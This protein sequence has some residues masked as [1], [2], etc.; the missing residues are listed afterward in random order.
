[1]LRFKD[2]V[3][4]VTGSA[5]GIGKATAQEFAKEGA[6][7][8]MCDRDAKCG[9][10]TLEELISAG[11]DAMFYRCDIAEAQD[12]QAILEEVG[13]RYGRLDIAVN[14][15]GVEGALAPLIDQIAE[16]FDRVL[17]INVR[18]TFLCMQEELK[19]MRKQ[20]SG[21][22]INGV[23]IAAHVGFPA[24]SAYT[25]SKHAIM[26]LT[27]AAA[28]EYAT[29]GIRISAISP[30]AVDTPM[31]DRFTGDEAAKQAMIASIPIKRLCEPREI[32]RGALFLASED[33]SLMVG[34]TLHA[35][36]GWAN[37]KP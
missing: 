29:A 35:D 9:L 3:V 11:V 15:A 31:T 30:G 24:C 16:E 21:V 26:G 14:N 5:N 33:A 4:L 20:Q 27:K 32:A 6:K 8:A 28:L 18:G 1:M 17:A 13:K 19:I 25:A 37:V 10:K 34:Q 36:G 12:I 22:I 7:V 23:S 2:K